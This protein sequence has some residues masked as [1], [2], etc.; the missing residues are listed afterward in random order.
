MSSKLRKT[1]WGWKLMPVWLA[2]V[3]FGLTEFF[4]RHPKITESIYSQ[5]L[6]PVFAFVLSFISKWISFSLD[7]V[8]YCILVFSFILLLIFPFFTKLKWKK[9][10]LIIIQVAAICYAL[11]YWSWGFNYYRSNLNERLS[12]VHSK[13]D[14]VEFTKVLA[15]LIIKTNAS[16]CSFDSISKPEIVRLVESSYRKHAAFLK[17]TYPQGVREA[18]PITLSS[19]FAK[20]SIAGYYGPFFSEV[21]LNK[22]L[23]LIEYPQVLAHESAHQFGITSEAEANF[24]SWLVCTQSESKHL[25]YSANLNTLGYFL[26]QAKHIKSYP[27]LVG[28]IDKRVINDIRTIQQHW[29][30]LRNEKIDKAAEKVNNAYLK[31]NKIEKG[32]ED[33]FGI[34][35]YVMDFSTDSTAQKKLNNL[36]FQ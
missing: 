23:L 8:F 24:Y 26:S 2:L 20:A 29:E 14:S 30:Q 28:Q 21:H 9:S 25:Q 4:A 13:P 15:N 31:T 18:K 33:Y 35:G 1:I 12:I 3:T 22:N 16:Y 17:I 7:D 5:A 11:F 19:F 10:I 34:V 32:V 36:D 27:F 6:Y